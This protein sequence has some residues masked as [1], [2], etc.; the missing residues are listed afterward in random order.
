MLQFRCCNT[1]CCN[2]ELP[3]LDA[4]IQNNLDAAI[5][6]RVFKFADDIKLVGRSSNIDSDVLQKDLNNLVEWSNANQMPF[7]Y[8]KCKIL[9]IGKKNESFGYT[10]DGQVLE[11]TKE[12]NDLGITINDTLKVSKQCE[13][14]SK[15]ASRMLGAINRNVTYKS[16]EVI[17]ALYC[18]YVRPHVEYCSPVWSPT[19]KKDMLCL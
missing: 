16:K 3:N 14:A 1:E 2:T 7:N 11:E 6:S 5:Q 15:R 8:S 12:V 17:K 10:M 13:K 4:A 18:S 19:Y 9:R